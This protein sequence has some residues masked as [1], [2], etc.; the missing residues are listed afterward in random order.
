M[1]D[2]MAP[3]FSGGLMKQLLFLSMLLFSSQAFCKRNFYDETCKF[4]STQG[5]ISLY[6]RYYWQ[7]AHTILISDA[8]GIDNY[9]YVYLPGSE[10]DVASDPETGEEVIVF[11]AV[12]DT[13]VVQTP[14]DDGC[15]QGY[16]A[17]FNRSVKIQKLKPMTSEVLHLKLGDE[18]NMI[19][20]YNHMII[21]GPHCNDDL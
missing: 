17:Q 14:Y 16:T 13:Q 4:D 18:V 8:P 1:F 7:G 11:G 6:K 3:I 2:L 20:N 12:R 10:G 21:S 9:P 19:C 5:E 15:W